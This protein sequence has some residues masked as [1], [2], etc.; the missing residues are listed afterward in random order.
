M[1]VHVAH[2]NSYTVDNDRRHQLSSKLAELEQIRENLEGKI[3][4]IEKNERNLNQ[5]LEE[6]RY[7]RVSIHLS[8]GD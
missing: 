3:K 6:L 8:V 4:D 2:I 7:A 5:K 1:I